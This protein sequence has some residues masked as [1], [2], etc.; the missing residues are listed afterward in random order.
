MT[1]DPG[2]PAGTSLATCLEVGAVSM[3]SED[4]GGSKV[5]GF[6]VGYDD[7]RVDFLAFADAFI[8]QSPDEVDVLLEIVGESQTAAA[9][10]G[11]IQ[12]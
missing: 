5:P 11:E 4:S 8:I 12:I 9:K 1:T 3:E 7:G 6:A 10:A 2:N